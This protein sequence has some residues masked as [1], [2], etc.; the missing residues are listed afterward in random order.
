MVDAIIAASVAYIGVRIV[1]GAPQRWEPTVVAIFLFGLAHGLGLSTRLQEL[2]LPDGGAL[3]TRIVAFNIGVEIG[4]LAALSLM[5]G[6]VLFFK[7]YVGRVRVARH[8]AGAALALT[9]VVA[10]VALGAVA[11]RP[12]DSNAASSDGS[13]NCS[14]GPGSVSF[15]DEITSGGHP[16][17][18][19]FGP[20]N[21]CPAEAISGTSWATA[22]S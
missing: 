14:A 11:V 16:A 12:N 18:A 19:F 13:G 7:R 9:G 2:P 15:G 20:T 22:T 10:A 1:R 6:A 8:S 3:V 21:L 5:A 17:K 4:Q